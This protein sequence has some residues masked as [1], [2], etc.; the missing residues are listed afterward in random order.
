MIEEV[1]EPSL[2]QQATMYHNASIVIQMHGAAL[3]E[4]TCSQ[5]ACELLDGCLSLHLVMGL[6]CLPLP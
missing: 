2:L 5:S 3:G 6:A 4:T 1:E